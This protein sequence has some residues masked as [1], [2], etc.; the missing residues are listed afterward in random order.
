EVG[1]VSASAAEARIAAFTPKRLFAADRR[2]VIEIK[3]IAVDVVLGRHLLQ[4]RDL[5]VDA[6][7]AACRG[8]ELQPVLEEVRPA[9]ALERRVRV[10]TDEPEEDLR[11]W[12]IPR[13]R[14]TNANLT[15]C[16]EPPTLVRVL[17]VLVAEARLE[18]LREEREVVGE[19]EPN[20]L[21]GKRE[22]EATRFSVG[23]PAWRALPT[24]DDG[25][26]DRHHA[27]EIGDKLAVRHQRH[28]PVG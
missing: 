12:S 10:V 21:A 18:L 17:V 1:G 9:L 24:G 8:Y 14:C 27:I 2:Q 22:G 16:A 6:C 13:R 19:R 4:R 23:A 7:E 25:L 28:E 20:T 15:Q 3:R 11:R 26:L 5:T